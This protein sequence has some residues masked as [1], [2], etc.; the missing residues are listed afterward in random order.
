MRST[1]LST[2][3]RWRS[4]RIRDDLIEVGGDESLAVAHRVVAP[5][6]AEDLLEPL[7][8]GEY[9]QLKRTTSKSPLLKTPPGPKNTWPGTYVGLTSMPACLS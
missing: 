6:A 2:R 8:S 3:S 7:E 5:P 1:R 4:S 9:V